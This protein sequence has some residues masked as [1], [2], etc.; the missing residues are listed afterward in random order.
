MVYIILYLFLWLL[1]VL[2]SMFY[3]YQEKFEG[4]KG[5][6]SHNNDHQY[7]CAERLSCQMMCVSF[8]S[9][10]TGAISGAGTAYPS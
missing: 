8:I 4:I 5:V 6:Q 9:N 2:A 10:A 3:L 1:E 7:W